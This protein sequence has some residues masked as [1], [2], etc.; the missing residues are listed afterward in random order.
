MLTYHCTE[1]SPVTLAPAF[2]SREPLRGY[3][4]GFSK[5]QSRAGLTSRHGKWYP[6]MAS[7]LTERTAYLIDQEQIHDAVVSI[8]DAIGEDIEREGLVQTPR[9]VADLYLELFSGIGRDPSDVLATTFEGT[10]AGLV[11]FAN[12]PFFSICEHHLLPFIGTASVG[13]LPDGRVV[14]ASKIPRALDIL[15][16]RPQ[17]QERLTAQLADALVDSLRPKGVGVV[18]R[19]EHMCMSLRGVKNPGVRMVTSAYRGEFETN[20]DLRREFQ[21]VSRSD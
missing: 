20:A 13:Y 11:T 3:A 2:S 4:A 19:A 1:L 12:L 21:L 8:L 14:G 15:A 16:R 7:H 5:G 10:D 17:M 6:S 9:R 18:L